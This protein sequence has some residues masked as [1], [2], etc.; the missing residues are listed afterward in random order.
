MR[1]KKVVITTVS[2]LLIVFC[3]FF[4]SAETYDFGG[5]TDNGVYSGT[6]AVDN[7]GNVAFTV[8]AATGPAADVQ[9]TAQYSDDTGRA[10]AG[11]E[12]RAV[13]DSAF[14]GSGAASS[15]GDTAST[16][17]HAI[18]NADINTQQAAVAG[19]GGVPGFATV[20]GVLAIQESTIL[21]EA[22]AAG[23]LGVSHAGYEA[24]TNTRMTGEGTI[25]TFQGAGAGDVNLLGIGVI[26]AVAGQDSFIDSENGGSASSMATGGG[27]SAETQLSFP[28]DGIAITG[29]VAA[30]GQVEVPGLVTGYGAVA[31]QESAIGSEN[32]GTAS[33]SASNGNGDEAET[34]A[35]FNGPGGIAMAQGAAAGQVELSAGLADMTVDGAVAGQSVF[36]LASGNSGT[37][38]SYATNSD[39]DT[40]G[41][42]AH[43]DGAGI[44]TGSQVAAA[45]DVEGTLFSTPFDAGGALATQEID[46]LGNNGGYAWSAAITGNGYEASTYSDYWGTGTLSA[47]Q[48]AAAAEIE[49]PGTVSVDGAAAGQISIIASTYA[50]HAYSF[51]GT[52]GDFTTS[53]ISEAS[54]GIEGGLMITEQGAATGQV[55]AP[56]FASVDGAVAGQYASIDPGGTGSGDAYTLA[57]TGDLY[58][59]VEV[60]TRSVGGN[61]IDDVI[62]GAAAGRISVPGT[63]NAEGAAAIQRSTNAMAATAIHGATIDPDFAAGGGGA[64]QYALAGR[65]TNGGTIEGANAWH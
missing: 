59:F 21:G 50:G 61:P 23:S 44:I 24:H 54:Y 46:V 38:G 7:S 34:W 47:M 60:Q 19:Q 37:I 10:A 35:E 16:G 32:G 18:G 41:T 53:A 58:D 42:R 9:V 55:D 2:L 56:G 27:N 22:A 29:Q 6:L 40:A 12:T 36:D 64:T 20:D 62:Q 57:Q 49:V 4:A 45:G 43:Y 1:H 28:T 30:A 26:G 65:V 17:A 11:Q 3:C 63:F 31:G 51:A 33:S 5:A 14:I 8:A 39:G 25:D 52:G 48:G 15:N 13:G